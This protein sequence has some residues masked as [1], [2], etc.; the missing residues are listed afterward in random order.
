M[1][2]QDEAAMCS[3]TSG[4]EMKEQTLGFGFVML[5]NLSPILFCLPAVQIASDSFQQPTY[6]A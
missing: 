2:L 6:E 5:H 3:R 4:N 1:E